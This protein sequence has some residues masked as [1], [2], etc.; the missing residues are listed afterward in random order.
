[1][2]KCGAEPEREERAV[3]GATAAAAAGIDGE[4]RTRAE[5]WATV[6]DPLSNVTIDITKQCVNVSLSCDGGAEVSPPLARCQRSPSA[7]LRAPQPWATV[8]VGSPHGMRLLDCSVVRPI[9]CVLPQCASL[10]RRDSP[11]PRARAHP[12]RERRA[13]DAVEDPGG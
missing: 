11:P 13:G 9:R 12:G 4:M 5:G 3:D 1:M 7:H 6:N 10:A 2:G 8:R